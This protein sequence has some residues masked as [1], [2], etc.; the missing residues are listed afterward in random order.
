MNSSDRTSSAR[1]ARTVQF[2]AQ[3]SAVCSHSSQ[4]TVFTDTDYGLQYGFMSTV[5]YAY[6]YDL[7]RA[8]VSIQCRCRCPCRFHAFSTYTSTV[9]YST[10]TRTVQYAIEST[11]STRILFFNQLL[12]SPLSSPLRCSSACASV[13]PGRHGTARPSDRTICRSAPRR[14]A[15]RRAAAAGAQLPDDRIG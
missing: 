5:Q 12:S 13:A 10:R 7:S 6:G 4:L 11:L 3:S 15:P 1:Y 8:R 9:Q 2:R 14:A